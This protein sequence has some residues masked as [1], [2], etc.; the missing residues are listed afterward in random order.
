MGDF[1]AKVEGLD[2]LEAILR[3]L[4]PKE[5]KTA[6]RRGMRKAAIPIKDAIVANAP[7]DTNF[8]AD[9]F[10]IKSKAGGGSEDDGSTGSI[11]V[12]VQ[13]TNDVYPETG[14]VKRSRRVAEVAAITEAGSPHEAA[15][16]FI[17]EAYEATKDQVPENVIR[18]VE[19]AIERINAKK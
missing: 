1:S 5:A 2:E 6:L 14:N 3:T 13:P 7:K 12:R 16:P 8:M 19:A 17:T 18:E 9:H 11:T 4:A 15:R 10:V